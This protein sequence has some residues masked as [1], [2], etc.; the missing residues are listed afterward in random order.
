MDFTCHFTTPE[1][2]GIGSSCTAKT[3]VQ[4]ARPTVLKCITPKADMSQSSS[5]GIR[6]SVMKRAYSRALS[7]V[8]SCSNGEP[9]Q[10]TISFLQTSSGHPLSLTLPIEIRIF[11]SETTTQG[12]YSAC[13]SFSKSMYLCPN[14]TVSHSRLAGLV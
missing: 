1:I 7:L 2:Y 11:R 9:P 3:R 6:P 14:I 13:L 8:A 10:A 4:N 5:P 12:Y